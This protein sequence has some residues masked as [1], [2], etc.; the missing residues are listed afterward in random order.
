[1]DKF[2]KQRDTKTIDE[3]LEPVARICFCWS[4]TKQKRELF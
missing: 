2:R 1:M 4:E 3:Q